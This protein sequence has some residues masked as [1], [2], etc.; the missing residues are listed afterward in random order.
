MWGEE[1]MYMPATEIA[2]IE[3]RDYFKDL[4]KINNYRRKVEIENE[5]ERLESRDR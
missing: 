5:N 1:I 3:S 2:M 4:E